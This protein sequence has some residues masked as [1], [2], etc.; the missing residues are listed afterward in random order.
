[1]STIAS[2]VTIL[3]SNGVSNQLLTEKSPVTSI[4]LTFTMFSVL[5][6]AIYIG[7][8]KLM[9]RRSDKKKVTCGYDIISEKN[10]YSEKLNF[11]ED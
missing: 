5:L 4:I 1:M 3:F 10:T 7:L 6:T 8:L 2:G 9:S 11:L